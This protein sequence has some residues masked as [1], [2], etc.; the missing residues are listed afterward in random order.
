[1]SNEWAK[2]LKMK[3]DM[4]TWNCVASISNSESHEL[5]AT[6]YIK[7]PSLFNLSNISTGYVRPMG[8]VVSQLAWLW[9]FLALAL[10]LAVPFRLLGGWTYTST[11]LLREGLFG[12]MPHICIGVFKLCMVFVRGCLDHATGRDKGRLFYVFLMSVLFYH[13]IRG[14]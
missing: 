2:N 10:T 6:G 7:L 5:G 14:L 11:C 1:M 9:C 3:R 12:G 13:V 8:E 4:R